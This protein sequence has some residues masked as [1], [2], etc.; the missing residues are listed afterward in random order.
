MV[1][2]VSSMNDSSRTD[3]TPL[4]GV[5]EL[6]ERQLEL[7][8]DLH[9]HPELSH[10]ETRTAGIAAEALREAGFEVHENVGTTGVVGVLSQ[11]EG[12]VVLVRADMDALP[13]QE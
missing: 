11:G 6:A 7:Y 1:Y 10:Q 12:P 9:A 8:Q 4:A 5:P 3:R 2:R 13:L